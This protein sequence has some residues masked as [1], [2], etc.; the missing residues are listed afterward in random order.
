MNDPLDAFEAASE[1]DQQ[2]S[3]AIRDDQEET[4]N[5]ALD[6]AAEVKKEIIEQVPG[7]LFAYLM[8]T[9]ETA[10]L[11]IEDL[12]NVDPT[13]SVKIRALQND[14]LAYKRVVSFAQTAVIGY[15]DHGASLGDG[16]SPTPD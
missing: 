13:D 15:Y 9:R 2:L 4:F 10:K 12:M 14:L 5:D 16:D 1:E 6:L 8:A 11:A 7:G 3:Q